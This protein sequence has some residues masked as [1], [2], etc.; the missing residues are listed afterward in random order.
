MSRPS[1]ATKARTYLTEGRVVIT[2]CTA[3]TVTAVVRGVGHLW[4]PTYAD[5]TW[6][7]DCP[8]RTDQCC[9]LQALRLVTAPDLQPAVDQC[10]P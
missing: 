3:D 2:S 7:C 4:H 5:G 10:A 6:S 9:H 1:A 8:A